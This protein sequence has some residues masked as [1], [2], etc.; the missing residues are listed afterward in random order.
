MCLKLWYGMEVAS[1]HYKTLIHAYGY[2]RASQIADK[3]SQP[4]VIII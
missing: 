2:S 3:L 1:N 4:Q